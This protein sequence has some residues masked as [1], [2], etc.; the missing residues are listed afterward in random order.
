MYCRLFHILKY[1]CIG[2]FFAFSIISHLKGKIVGLFVI[3]RDSIKKIVFITN[4]E[5]NLGILRHLAQSVIL[6]FSAGFD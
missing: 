1:M 6:P 4:I 5:G 2:N 3:S